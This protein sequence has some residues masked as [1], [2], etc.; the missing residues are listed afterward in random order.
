MRE[1]AS[2]FGAASSAESRRQI[3]AFKSAAHAFMLR[4]EKNTG[5][6]TF[7]RL[8][9]PYAFRPLQ[10]IPCKENT[11]RKRVTV[12]KHVIG[13]AAISPLCRLSLPVVA[14]RANTPSR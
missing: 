3:I 6:Y 14:L 10:P 9:N 2:I 5:D 13:K 7:V 8:T 4:T 11:T 1:M 12:Y